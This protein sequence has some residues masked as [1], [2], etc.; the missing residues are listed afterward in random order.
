M[1]TLCPREDDVTTFHF[2]VHKT[3]CVSYSRVMFIVH[4]IQIHGL[5]PFHYCYYWKYISSSVSH[6]PYENYM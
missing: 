4:C 5:G 6:D 2:E 1:Q 3:I